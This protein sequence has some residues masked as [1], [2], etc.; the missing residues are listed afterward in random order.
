MSAARVRRAVLCAWLLAC[1]AVAAAAAP[2]F[3]ATLRAFADPAEP[4][5][6]YDLA[7]TAAPGEINHVDLYAI[8]QHTIRVVDTGAVI[9]AKAPCRALAAH[10]A[11]CTTANLATAPSL[12]DAEV[13]AGDM[14]DVVVTHGPGL[15]GSGGPGDDRLDARGTVVSAVLSG[16]G[17]HD[18]I[19][20][21]TNDDTLTDGD[22]S[23]AADSDVIDG[24]P[25]RD[26][27]SYASRSAGVTV[28]LADRRPAGEPGER[29]VLK[30]IEGAIGGAGADTLIGTDAPDNRLDGG[31]GDDRIDGRAGIDFLDGGPGDDRV[32][33]GRGADVI[34][35]GRGS[36]RLSG[37][38]GGDEI[39]AG[40]DRT[41]VD[42]I[43]GGL[44][45]DVITLNRRGGN[46]LSCGGG[47][48]SLIAAPVRFLTPAD[49]ESGFFRRSTRDGDI[50][51]FVDLQPHPHG[52]GRVVFAV[53]CPTP[54]EGGQLSP[55]GSIGLR[56]ASAPHRVLGLGRI[57]T[58]QG[59]KCDDTLD[60]P[61]QVAVR[62]NALG[63]SLMAR[64]H[65]VR[66]TVT[67]R[68][69]RLITARWTIRLSLR[70]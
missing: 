29:D 19:L 47:D 66:A 7:Y 36:D 2:S 68:A 50:T 34:G 67:L 63:R 28:D 21:G 17:G 51:L 39:D 32:S 16:G 27:V 69:R 42:R 20:G 40:S 22:T 44:G 62:L 5:Y 38:P 61:L 57:S 24:G 9:T 52:R 56:E 41:A 30:S 8:D 43:R 12:V 55:A 4:S 1:A 15:S 13:D 6:F 46:R 65:G 11:Q 26:R 10:T 54:E 23:G 37:G 18:T 60:R 35:G 33:G 53:D 14:N 31:A 48:D 45:A 3:A 64:R 70:P 25:G 59:A 49:C 58:R